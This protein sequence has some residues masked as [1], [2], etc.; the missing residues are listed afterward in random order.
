MRDLL[1]VCSDMPRRA[2]DAGT[3]L[4]EQGE[5][6]GRL[7][8]LVGGRIEILRGET[9]VAVLYEPGSVV[10]DMSILLQIPHTATARALTD[11][12]VHVI[13]NGADFFR[14]RPQAS[15]F[16]ARMLAQRLNGATTYLVDLKKQFAGESNHLEMVGDVLESLIYRHRPKITP[17]SD[18]ERRS[19]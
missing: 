3:V 7:Y 14:Q 5:A 13:E 1:E 15:Y 6:T 10:G 16:V 11:V 9:Q 4:L 18:R 17:G 19:P 8:V 12:E 2:V